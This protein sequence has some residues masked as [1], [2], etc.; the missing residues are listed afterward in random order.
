LTTDLKVLGHLTSLGVEYQELTCDPDLA[1]TAAFCAAYGVPP[2]R[3]ANTILVASRRPEGKFVACVVLATTRLDVNGIVRRRLDVKKTSF[4]SA[5][6]TVA[7][8]GMMIG[9][10]TPFGLGQEMMVW[11]DRLV[12]VPE[13]IVIGAGTR[14]A[15]IRLAPVGLTRIATAEVVNDLAISAS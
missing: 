1:D 10:V 6:E 5:D 4:A 15:K 13:W 3:T 7:M 9:G 2:D 11:I 12:M 14:S 8:T